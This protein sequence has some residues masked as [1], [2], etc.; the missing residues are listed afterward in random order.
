MQDDGKQ[1]D[2]LITVGTYEASVHC[3]KLALS[4]HPSRGYETLIEKYFSTKHHSS[5]VR[6][7]ASSCFDS[8]VIVSAAADEQIHIYNGRKKTFVADIMVDGD[9]TS[10]HLCDHQ[11]KVVSDIYPYDIFGESKTGDVTCAPPGYAIATTMKGFVHVWKLNLDWQPVLVIQAHSKKCTDIA[12]HPSGKLG[13]SVGDDRMLSIID[14]GKG[15][16]ALTIKHTAKLEKCRFAG[17][18]GDHYTLVDSKDNGIL[19]VDTETNKT[20]RKIE[21]KV[22]RSR[23]CNVRFLNASL[24]LCAFE[25]GSLRMYDI[26]TGEEVEELNL[27]DEIEDSGVENGRSPICKDF[28][29]VPV[30]Q[31]CGAL[32]GIVVATSTS[33]IMSFIGITQSSEGLGFM[34]LNHIHEGALRATCITASILKNENSPRML[35]VLNGI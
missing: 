10:L 24:L 31:P 2:F 5:F 25:D 3:W 19:V 21:V 27:W 15:H 28:C 22:K 4:Y 6:C 1:Q 34:Y 17:I 18:T 13:L 29:V 35:G 14:M 9:V 26:L 20:Q 7:M 30:V 33:G 32:R 11:G 23:I 12:L 16:V 8:S